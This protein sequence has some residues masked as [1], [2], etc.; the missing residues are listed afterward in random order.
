MILFVKLFK[1]PRVRAAAAA[2]A[3]AAARLAR[4]LVVD[5]AAEPVEVGR[6]LVALGPAAGKVVVV[7]LRAAVSAAAAGIGAL[8]A[9]G[10]R[11]AAAGGAALLV[12]GEPIRP[13][14]RPGG[15]G[16]GMT[17]RQL[18]FPVGLFAPGGA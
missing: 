10:P 3:T 1:L 5:A 13:E 4:H 15:I 12:R 11:A 9:G 8:V 18:V 2:T 17:S 14:R 16:K 7:A 6:R